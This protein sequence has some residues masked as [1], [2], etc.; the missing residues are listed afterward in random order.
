MSEFGASSGPSEGLLL[1]AA[2]L[3][4]AV[5]V[6]AVCAAAIANAKFR[7]LS[8]SGL[9]QFDVTASRV[10]DMITP[11]PELMHSTTSNSRCPRWDCCITCC[12][13]F[14]ALSL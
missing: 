4:F 10:A 13:G 9:R 6:L 5:G 12:R 11:E 2:R 14:P 7:W 1:V 3:S 8:A